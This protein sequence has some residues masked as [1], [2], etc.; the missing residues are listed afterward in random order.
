MKIIEICLARVIQKRVI[1]FDDAISDFFF[2]VSPIK[3]WS[4][5]KLLQI[6]IVTYPPKNHSKYVAEKYICSKSSPHALLKCFLHFLAIQSDFLGV[7]HLKKINDDF[8]LQQLCFQPFFDWTNQNIINFQCQISN[9]SKEL[10][11][12]LSQRLIPSWFWHRHQTVSVI[13]MPC[14]DSVTRLVL[15]KISEK[16]QN[17]Q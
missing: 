1:S 10:S 12:F 15:P 13:L 16:C 9:C 5:T 11:S 3:K 6:K 7:S 4:K 8:Y 14:P 2:L 17:P